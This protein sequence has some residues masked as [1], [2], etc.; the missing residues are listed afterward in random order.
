MTSAE[1]PRPTPYNARP[2]DKTGLVAQEQ[3]HSKG[4]TVPGWSFMTRPLRKKGGK[5]SETT[6]G[7]EEING[8]AGDDCRASQTQ[9]KDSSY[10]LEQSDTLR[11]V[12]SEDE[13]L[14]EEEGTSTARG[15]QQHDQQGQQYDRAPPGEGCGRPRYKV[16]KRRWFGVVQLV[17]LNTIVSWDVSAGDLPFLFAGLALI[18]ATVALFLSQFD[19]R[20]PVLWSLSIGRQL[21]QYSVP[22]CLCLHLTTRHLYP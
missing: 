17:L 11:E 16:Y 3:A 21:A 12:T 9:S 5:P 10:E 7:T 2:R 13:L 4:E 18:I 1:D 22:L 6:T 14:P 8:Q 15:G 19:N 20:L